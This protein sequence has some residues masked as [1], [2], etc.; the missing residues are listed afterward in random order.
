MSASTVLQIGARFLT[1]EQV[2]PLISK[3]RLMPQLAREI[4]IDEAIQDY[5]VTEAEYLAAYTRFYQQQQFGSD[6]D[7]DLWLQQQRLSKDDLAD[8]V[9]RELR[10]QQFKTA[11][12]ETQVESHFCQRKSQIDRVVFSMIRVKEI[13]IAEEIYFRL[14]AQEATF[15][16]LAPRYS[17]GIEAKTKGISGPVELGKLDPLLA[18][19]LITLQPE[20]ILPPTQIGGWWVV[21][22]LE[23]IIPAQLDEEMRQALTEELF[24][25]WIGA[26]VQKL[27]ATPDL[28]Q[29]IPILLD[30]N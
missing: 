4:L 12:W 25:H 15:V 21:V 20:E 28:Q 11:K 23:T 14:A 10:L 18:N 19:A 30:T 26:E 27:L 1:T 3:Y 29:Q 24:N 16:E 17:A 13:D 5:D 8:L 22:Q 9:K 7:L 2:I 6:Q